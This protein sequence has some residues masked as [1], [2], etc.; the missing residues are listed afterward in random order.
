MNEHEN[1]S[2]SPPDVDVHL[3]CESLS[4]DP[5]QVQRLARFVL[6]EEKKEHLGLS[7]AFINDEDIAS[8]NKAY[9]NHEGPTDVISFPLLEDHDSDWILGEV[10][11]SLD[12][13]LRQAAEFQ[14]EPLWEALLYVVHGTLHL[15]DYD[16]HDPKDKAKMH[17]RQ[18]QLLEDFLAKDNLKT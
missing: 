6:A 7:V 2:F 17:A 15:L 16:D 8:M 3:S 5:Q 4:I 10:V 9:L 12:T 14:R 13:A 18:E 1:S 11:V